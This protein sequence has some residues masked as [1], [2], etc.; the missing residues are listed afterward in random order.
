MRTVLGYVLIIL[1]IP[2]SVLTFYYADAEAGKVQNFDDYVEEKIV[3]NEVD[4]PQASKIKDTNGDI[5]V[6]LYQPNRIVVDGEKIPSFLKELFLQSE[7]KHFYE[8]SGIDAA[9]V[10]RA[11][12]V[13]AQSDE[14]EQGASTITQQVAR[15]IYLTQDRTLARKIAEVLYS[16]QIEK[17]LDKEEILDLYLNVIYFNHNT[18]GVEAAAQYYFQKPVDKLSKA[19]MAFIAAI[20]NNPTL[21]DPERNVENTKKRQ[22]RLIDIMAREEFITP[23]EAEQIK[24]EK[25]T[26][27]VRDRLD[28]YPDYS[29]YVMHE[30]RELISESEGFDQQLLNA[31]GDAREAIQQKLS[32]RVA[33]VL[34]SGIVIH[35][36]LDPDIQSKAVNAVNN[37]LA[38]S[39][40]QAS[41]AV[42]GNQSHDIVAMSG[43]KGFQKTAFNRAFQ[44]YRQPGS[45]IKPLLD[46][47]P[48]LDTYGADINEMVSADNYCYQGYCP[49]NYSKTEYGMV[50]IKE[51]LA[52]SHNTAALRLLI[53]TGMERAYSYL[54][55]FEFE[56][57][58][59]TDHNAPA[60]ALGGFDYGM[61]TLEMASAYTS[62]VDGTYTKP[63]AIKRVTDFHGNTLFAWDEE[64]VRVWSTATSYKMRAM[65]TNVVKNGT[66]KKAN[67]ATSYI[68]GKT[69]TTN[70]YR[71]LWFVG[72]TEGYTA[73]VWT[74][75]DKYE[76]KWDNIR[77]MESYAPHQLIWKRIMR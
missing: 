40:V 27:K 7:D 46:Y 53:K 74:G 18:Y 47:A 3:I 32:D 2:L 58:T 75:K 13:N 51:A 54:D 9:A 5:Y 56:K 57:V 36:A 16:Y 8:H 39:S 28:K 77:F 14:I 25:I 11:F 50:P 26:L 72:L 43:G 61:T 30:F 64:P 42:I 62:F 22:E 69:G 63:H 44:G 17:K 33:E 52:K 1:L 60:T 76:N 21:Y 68:G 73:A 35:T 45:T 55:K 41:A 67:F 37:V 19:Q 24:S 12:M 29:T 49:S 38:G 48:Y 23:E 59:E 15:N 70:S 4:L 31:E 10:I 20:P 34:A 65:L 6:E 66:G 71:D